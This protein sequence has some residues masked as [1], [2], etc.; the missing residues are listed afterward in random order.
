MLSS[1]GRTKIL[2][3]K[4]IL[5]NIIDNFGFKIQP[6]KRKKIFLVRRVHQK[7]AFLTHLVAHAWIQ[8][9]PRSQGLSPTLRINFVPKP[10]DQTQ[11]ESLLSLSLHRDG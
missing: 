10:R 9:Q 11:P 7:L 6:V 1:S 2:V 8:I 4:K 3:R 5:W